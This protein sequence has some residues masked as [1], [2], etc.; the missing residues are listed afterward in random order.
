MI[1]YDK[2]AAQGIELSYSTPDIANQRLRTLQTL[3]INAG[4]R[5]LDVGCGTGF[6]TKEL[7]MLVGESGYVLGVD[8]S[9][10]MLDG[11]RERCAPFPQIELKQAAAD[12]LPV[13]DNSFDVVTCTQ[14][15][16]YV[17]DLMAVLAELYRVLKPGGRIAIVET[18]WRGVVINSDDE[19]M[20]RQVFGAFSEAV[21]NPNL[22]PQLSP[23]LREQG[24][25]VLR[26]EPISIINTSMTP[27][28][29]SVT[30]V[31]WM[32]DIAEKQGSITSEQRQR[33][34]GDL[35]DKAAKGGYFFCVNRF[36]FS[37]T[38]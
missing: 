7:A 31:E 33:W 37:A 18:D 17:P 28:N 6:L 5:V 10:D 26:V 2:K 34:L 14:V 19:A 38:K 1:K 20:T 12:A 32:S 25:H 35:A 22:P 30:A 27:A 4:E 13:A 9:A 23:L 15:L 29:F 16:L 11:G 21:P 24:F 8:N 36:L 3:G